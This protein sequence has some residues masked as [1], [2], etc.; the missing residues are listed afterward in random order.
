MR[1]VLMESSTK[2]C[3]LDPL[4]HHLFRE[5]I[6]DLLPFIFHM[7]S[8]SINGGFLLESQKFALVTPV[9][10]KQFLDPNKPKNYRPISN[11]T[12]ISKV[13]ERLVGRQ[14]TD[15]LKR[16]ELMPVLQLAYRSGHSTESCL[17]KVMSDIF[18]AADSGEISIVGLLDL[19]AAFDTVDHEILLHRLK[20]SFGIGMVIFE[21][22]GSFLTNRTQ[23][24]VFR[25]E[26][27]SV[28]RLNCGVSQGSVLGPLLLSSIQ[29][30]SSAL[31]AAWV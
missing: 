13:I 17:L 1:R 9:I 25:G 22:I 30:M 11:L 2:T 28:C 31:Q 20:S 6:D 12:L 19:S 5:L 27:S 24:V 23:A 29:Q 16:C 26:R 18:D 21:W 3:A 15:H 14:I 8:S 7:C 10:K 4:P